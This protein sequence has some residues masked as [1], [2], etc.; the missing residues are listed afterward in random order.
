MRWCSSRTIAQQNISTRYGAWGAAAR[1]ASDH[2]LLGVGPGNYGLYYNRLTGQPVGGLTLTVAHDALLD[3]G[4]ELGLIAM[5]LLA[6]YLLMAFLRLTADDPARLRR[7]GL[8][9]HV[10]HLADDRNRE[11]DLPLGAVLPPVLA[12]RRPRRRDLGGRAAPRS[13]AR[14]RVVYVSTIERGGPLAHLVQLAPRVAAAGAEVHVLCATDSIAESFRGL[15]VSAEAVPVGHKLDLLAGSRLWQRLEGADV[16]HTHDRR[17]GLFGRLCG[18]LRGAHVLHTLHG[19]P[20]EIAARIG[21]PDAPDPPGVSR[22]RLVWLEHGYLATRGRADAARSRGRA[23]A[24]DGRLPARAR[25]LA[26]AAARDTPRRRAWSDPSVRRTRRARRRRRGEP[27]VLE[28]NR[29]P[30]RSGATGRRAGTAGD[31]RHR[32]ASRSARAPGA[33]RPASTRAS[34]ASSPMSRERLPELDVLVQP[35]RGRQPASLD[36]RGDGSRSAGRRHARRRDPGAHRRR[37]DRLCRRARERHAR[38]RTRSS[39]LARARNGASSSA[40]RPPSGWPSTSRRRRSRGGWSRSTR[41][42]AHPPRDPG[43]RHRGCRAGASL[44]LPRRARGRP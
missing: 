24:G 7:R 43:A 25:L 40:A 9:P 10:T 33:T 28:G 20:E 32:L 19:M 16:V 42:C 18:R 41:N 11:R 5:S 35:S 34:M 4:A 27:R 12:D 17:A 3:V 44:H 14:M 6:L 15:G 23:L 38:S 1:L 13:R 37:R 2:P 29:P 26:A 36:P 39:S 22:G 8:R 31:L 30:D 21:R